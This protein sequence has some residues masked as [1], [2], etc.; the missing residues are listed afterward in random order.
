MSEEILAVSRE[1]D[2]DLASRPEGGPDFELAR[3]NTDLLV[4]LQE[5]TKSNLTAEEKSET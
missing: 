5:N 2:E 1:S 4:M 3:H